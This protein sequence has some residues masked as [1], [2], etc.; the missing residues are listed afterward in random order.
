MTI[1]ELRTGLHWAYK[2]TYSFISIFRRCIGVF[3]TPKRIKYFF[4]LLI[5]NFGHRFSCKRMFRTA[6]NPLK[7]TKKMVQTFQALEL[8]KKLEKLSHREKAKIL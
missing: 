6:W 7:Q 3:K 1:E 4:F 2:K 8:L 5:F